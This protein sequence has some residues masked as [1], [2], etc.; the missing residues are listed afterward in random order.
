LINALVRKKYSLRY[1]Y[2]KTKCGLRKFEPFIENDIE[3][4]IRRSDFIIISTQESKIHEVVESASVSLRLEGKI[5]FHTSNSLS[6]DELIRLKEKGA[7]TASFSPLQTFSEYS[8]ENENT[9]PGLFKDI[10]FLVEGDPEAVKLAESIASDLGAH[11]ILVDKKE[12]IDYHIAAV[13]ASN[14]LISI[15]KLSENQLK[16]VNSNINILMP[17]VKQTLKNVESNGVDATLTG[18]AKR[19]E[20]GIIQKH[21][22]HLVGSEADLYK[23]LTDFLKY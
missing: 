10:Y 19:K 15:L 21:L 17:L 4:I 20:T 16:K 9:S 1:I 13:C 12:K 2:K 14:F 18:P 5:F 23:A 8:T 6:S 11:V 3:L 7:F 22:D